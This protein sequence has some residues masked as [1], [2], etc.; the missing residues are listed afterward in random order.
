MVSNSVRAALPVASTCTRSPAGPPRRR[1]GAVA[2]RFAPRNAPPNRAA[3]C[4]RTRPSFSAA[5]SWRRVAMSFANNRH[6][7]VSLSSRWANCRAGKSGRAARN[8]STTPKAL[9]VPAWTPRPAG[10]SMTRSRESSRRTRA[11]IMSNRRAE[12]A[13]L[14]GAAAKVGGT[15][16]RSPAC[17]RRSGLARPPFT[18]AS[19]RR[20]IE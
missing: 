11:R 5:L 9:P 19:P 8:N 17:R 16:T 12:G 10:L 20:I 13:A 18:R 1:R 7:E 14:A 4:L 2:T 15:R 3:Y 6:P